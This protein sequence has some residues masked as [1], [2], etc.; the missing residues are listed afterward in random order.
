M[1]YARPSLPVK[2][3]NHLTGWVARI[4]LAPRKVVVLEVKGRKSGLARTAT[5]NLVRVDGQEYLVAPRGNTEWSRNA[6]AAGEGTIR[7]GGSRRVR[8]E[9]LPVGQRAPIIQAYL[10]ENAWVTQREFGV[11]P[12]A[13]I[14]EFQRIAGRHPVFRVIEL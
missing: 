7:R 13:P 3:M 6:R 4:G 11:S 8:L 2:V 9:E 12:K 5:V 14:E 10:K 1:H